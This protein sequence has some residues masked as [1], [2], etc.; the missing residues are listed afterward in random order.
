[1]ASQLCPLKC[2][3]LRL[4][5]H[6]VTLPDNLCHLDMTVSQ[7][8]YGFQTRVW[9]NLWNTLHMMSLNFPVRPTPDDRRRYKAFFESLQWVLPCKSCRESYA[10]FISAKG[11]P[12]HLT[13][14]TMRDRE[15]VARWMYDVHCAVSKRI[16]KST[17]VSFEGMCR[18]F[19]QFRAG[20]CTKHSCDAKEQK[21]RR[22]A[23]VL[24]M[25]DET[26]AKMGFRSSLVVI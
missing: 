13:M 14:S 24:V 5:V 26:Y 7:S 19:E 11:K 9:G 17:P 20:D 6:G 3:Y 21:K 15:S 10:R 18:K 25:D 1:M 8:E 16:G 22:R 4:M 2:S 23:V 12:T